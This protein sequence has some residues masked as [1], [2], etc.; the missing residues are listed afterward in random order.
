[1]RIRPVH[2]ALSAPRRREG[3]TFRDLGKSRGG[4]S[5][6]QAIGAWAQES[7]RYTAG[8]RGRQGA[9]GTQEKTNP[10]R[11]DAGSG[12]TGAPGGSF[13]RGNVPSC[14][15]AQRRARRATLGCAGKGNHIFG[16]RLAPCRGPT[17]G[18]Q[19]GASRARPR[20]RANDSFPGLRGIARCESSPRGLLIIASRYYER[21][22][23]H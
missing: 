12:V 10:P 23:C 20:L 16:A 4:N 14:E 8:T 19:V 6:M 2:T 1:L 7:C 13:Q 21:R 18:P 15:R 22:C 17:A 9:G 5:A 11:R 3:R